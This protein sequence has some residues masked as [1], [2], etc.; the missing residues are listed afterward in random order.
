MKRPSCV[1]GLMV[2]VLGVLVTGQPKTG[3]VEKELMDLEQAWGTA[4]LKADMAFLDRIL[5]DEYIE[6]DFEG[7][8][9]NK[10]QALDTLKS[11]ESVLTSFVTDDMKVKVYG[12]T[13]VVTGRNTSKLSFKGKDVSGVYRWTDTW[14]K[15]DGRWQCVAS[16]SS[17]VA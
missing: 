6:T 1:V 3:S 8:M 11:G 15:K 5:S 7:V 17:K 14:V 13:A 12:T 10:K 4:W 2:L 16:H 9:R